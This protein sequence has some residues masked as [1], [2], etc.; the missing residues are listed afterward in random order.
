MK[1]TTLIII[2][3]SVSVFLY[4]A[5][6]FPLTLRNLRPKIGV[7]K[8]QGGIYSSEQYVNWI[9]KLK[10]NSQVKGILL[11]VNSPGGGV[12]ASDEIYNALMD[13]KKTGRP[14]VAYFGSVAASG[15]YYVGCAA[16]VIV[17]N[18]NTIT[19]S[20][21]VIAEFPV[22]KNLLK[23]IGVDFI[24]I[25]SRDKKDLGSPW[26]EMTREEKKIIKSL[27]DETYQNFLKIVSE[28][29]NI[30]MDSLYKIADGRIFSGR[31][32]L[33]Y[34]LVDTLGTIDTAIE[35]LKQK[36]KI[37]GKPVLVE[38]RKRLSLL[39]LIT[40]EE[41]KISDIKLDYRMVLP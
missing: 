26:R 18:P 23:K 22:V 28:S 32:A 17:S 25:K 30:P 4:F 13:F 39:S 33:K 34:G 6:L 27:I 19:G 24:V 3:V 38:P 21:G 40:G 37:K 14:L 8:I 31:Q 12:V 36:A 10:E 1:K 7:V 29:R 2:L 15:G 35:I 11:V 20:I 9:K 5:I 41:T 16:D